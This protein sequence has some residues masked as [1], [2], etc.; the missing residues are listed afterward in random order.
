MTG[1]NGQ[2][3]V[4]P[5]ALGGDISN[6]A[7]ATIATEEP[8]T[9][10]VTIRGTK[11]IL[12][13]RWQCDAVEAKAA[14]AKGSKAKKSDDVESYVWR[15]PDGTLGLPGMYLLGSMTDPRNGAA[16][17]RQDPRSSRKSAL[18]LVRASVSS[19]TDL[20]PLTRSDGSSATSWDYLD[21]RRVTVQRQGVTRER[22]ALAEGWQAEFQLL[23]TSP[24]Y[25]APVFLHDLLSLGG[26]TVGVG[27]FRP[28]YGRF[29][30]VR[31]DVGFAA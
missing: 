9:A 20:A 4:E 13:H 31:F 6:A 15:C 8:Y 10:T 14:A 23:V 28:T 21:R 18:D 30:V 22:P 24:E 27:D 11:A 12:F 19:L 26:R 16:K 25:V 29:Q 17:Y 3:A 5:R 2:A 7:A 1:S